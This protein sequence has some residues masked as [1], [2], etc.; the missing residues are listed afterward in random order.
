MNPSYVAADITHTVPER[1]SAYLISPLT[2]LLVIVTLVIMFVNVYMFRKLWKMKKRDY[3]LVTN[4]IV[5]GIYIVFSIISSVLV[6]RLGPHGTLTK[7][8]CDYIYMLIPRVL[9]L[10]TAFINIIYFISNIC[11]KYKKD[12][13]YEETVK[14]GYFAEETREEKQPKE[15]KHFDLSSVTENIKEKIDVEEIKEK[16]SDFTENIKEVINKKVNKE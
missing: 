11:V 5:I 13:E 15:E 14:R 9:F 6:S 4:I 12:K 10:I 2:N 3:M 8:D 16:V 1:L 7:D